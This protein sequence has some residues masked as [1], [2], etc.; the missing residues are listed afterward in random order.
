MN[1]LGDIK[2]I[3]FVGPGEVQV[4]YEVAGKL[5]SRRGFVDLVNSMWTFK[6]TV[7]WRPEAPV[8]LDAPEPKGEA[9]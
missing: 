8:P 3:D 6:A 7:M 2:R 5:F 9:A 4:V 1:V